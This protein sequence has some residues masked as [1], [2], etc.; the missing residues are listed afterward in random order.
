MDAYDASSRRD[1]GCGALSVCSRLFVPGTGQAVFI[2][3]C[4]VYVC[5]TTD[6]NQLARMR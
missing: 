4:N 6:L 5:G 1:T 2:F 3:R